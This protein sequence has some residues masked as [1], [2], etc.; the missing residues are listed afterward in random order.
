MN[1]RRIDRTSG[2]LAILA[3]FLLI[4]PMIALLAK[5]PW[6]SFTSRLT[7]DQSVS[8]IQ[9]SL[10]S[11]LLAAGISVVLG[12]PLAWVLARGN[13]RITNILR[14][15]VLAP[16]VLPPTVA[17][18]ALLALL[19]RDGLMGKYIYQATG[20]SMPFTSVAVV[21]TGVFVGMPFLAL[22]VESNFRHLPKDLEE[23]AMIDRASTRDVFSL[24]ALPQM[25]NGIATGAVLAWARALGEFGATMMFAGSLPG[26]TQTWAMQVYI[27][28]D[29]DTGSAYTLSAV[30]L[31]I[32]VSVVFALR[33]LLTQAITS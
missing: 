16:I 10:W 27:D 18:M 25:R 29:I 23:A 11:S 24:V 4:A 31:V 26:R 33:K 13:E 5:V 22:I 3:S 6:S 32:A 12:V 19:G 17:G 8:A 7:H 28:M 21:V 14:P 30:M 15:I 1:H 20:W 2:A 9:L